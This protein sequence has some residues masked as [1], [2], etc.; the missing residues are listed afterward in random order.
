MEVVGKVVVD[1]VVAVINN[2]CVTFE[3]I[4]SWVYSTVLKVPWKT[5]L[6]LDKF[7]IAFYELK[8]RRLFIVCFFR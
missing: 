7:Y 6:I 5:M 4:F 1:V 8:M 2:V 3:F